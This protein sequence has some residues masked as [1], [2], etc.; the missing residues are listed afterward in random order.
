[1]RLQLVQTLTARR[2]KIKFEMETGEGDKISIM[3]E[4]SLSREKLYQ[5][6][7][8]L[9]LVGGVSE[10]SENMKG[11]KLTKVMDTIEKHFPFSSF[12]SRDIVEAYQFEHREQLP[13]STASTYLARLAERGFLERSGAG[14][15]ARYRLLHN[16]MR[17]KEFEEV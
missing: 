7:D 4:G 15:L 13:L 11:S 14:N 3:F 8:F 6:A 12:T 16:D 10:P 17:Q 1:M 5:L 9:E 2:K